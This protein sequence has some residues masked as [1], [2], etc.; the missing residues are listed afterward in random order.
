VSRSL[1]RLQALLLGAVVLLG[2][3]LS[4]LGLFAVGSRGWF[5]KDALHVG[6]GFREIRG[7]EV[8]TRVRI[9]GMDAGEVVSLTPPDSLGQPVV[10]GLRLKGEFRNLVRTDSTVQIVSEGMLG[11]KVLEI[12]Q[13]P[14]KTGE[15]EAALAQDGDVLTSEPSTELAD[16][17][18]QVGQTLK[19][20]QNG[21]GT[22]GKLARDPQVYNALLALAVQSTDTMA[23]LQQDAEAMK[24]LPLV[25]GYV[26]DPVALLV[27]PDCERNRKCFAEEELFEPGRAVLTVQGRQRLDALAPWLEGMKHKGSEVVVVSYADPK[28]SSASTALTITRQQSEAVC[29]YLKKQHGAQKMGLFTS[30]TVKPLGRGVNPPPQLERELLP[31]ARVEVLVFVPQK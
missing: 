15:G 25:R 23:S 18:D 2:I 31:P 16:V 11:A 28:N 17:L 10:L 8:G 5:G 22:I 6:V 9:Q 21:E 26:E 29:E 12:H 1:S 30:R 13:G 27:R 7:V 19:G 4:V 20:I 14:P 3:G 24:K